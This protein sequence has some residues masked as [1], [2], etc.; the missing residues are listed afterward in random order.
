[1]PCPQEIDDAARRRLAKQLY[2]PLPCEASR[3]QMLQIHLGKMRYTLT[4]EEI[5]LVVGKTDGYSGSDLRHLV[6]AH[7]LT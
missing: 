4:P 7:R 5:Q 6:G 2:I 3:T 1:M